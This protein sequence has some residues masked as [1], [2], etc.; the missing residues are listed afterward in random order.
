MSLPRFAPAFALFVP[1][2]RIPNRRHRNGRRTITQGGLTLAAVLGLAVLSAPRP[3]AAAALVKYDSKY[4]TLYTDVDEQTAHEALVRMTAMAEAYHARTKSFAGQLRRKFPF[5]LYQTEADYNDAGGMKGSAGVFVG[6]S[7]GSGKLMAFVGRRITPYTWHTVQHE[8]FHQFAHAVIGGDIP[9]WL[10]EGLA[11]YFGEGL[12]TGDSILTGIVPPWRLQRLQGEIRDGRLKPVAKLMAVGGAQ[13]NAELNIQN[14]DQAWS[15]VHFL[16]HADDGRYAP[17]FGQCIREISA[18][19][20]FDVAWRDAIGSADGF[21]EKWKAYWLA[22]PRS[23]THRL[24]VQATVATLT[25]FLARAVAQHQAFAD[26]RSFAAAA[27]TD[28]GL[29]VSPADWLPHSLLVDALRAGHLDRA[30]DG[31]GGPPGPRWELAAGPNRQPTLTAV[32]ADGTRLTGWFTLAGP[33]VAAVNVDVDD[34]AK[35][36]ADATAARDA[37]DKAKARTMV[38]AALNQHSRSPAAAA[39]VAFLKTCR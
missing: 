35:V 26:V 13:W 19:K 1:S 10:N 22:Q 37:G 34:L 20:P 6:D 5:Y 2:Q 25:S 27:D 3:A 9:T 32:D 31:G 15:M 24:Y 8:G 28:A 21:E 23:P 39:A 30:D 7:D 33:R 29:K 11:E 4:Y 12:Y 36:V 17:A 18:G 16:V 38:T 14:Y